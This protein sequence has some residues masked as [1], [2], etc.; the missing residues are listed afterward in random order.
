MKLGT[1]PLGGVHP[2]LGLGSLCS[3]GLFGAL[4]EASTGSFVLLGDDL[5][6]DNPDLGAGGLPLPNFDDDP[7]KEESA[8]GIYLPQSRKKHPFNLPKPEDPD[9]P[10]DTLL[11][12]PPPPLL[13]SSKPDNLK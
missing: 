9:K 1:V 2:D 4:G 3:V 10:A 8:E 13:F 7:K 12:T 11:Q 6:I 5:P